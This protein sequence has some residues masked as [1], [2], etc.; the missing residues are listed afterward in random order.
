VFETIVR[1]PRPVD[2]HVPLEVSCL[3]RN[4]PQ[5]RFCESGGPMTTGSRGRAKVVEQRLSK[6][7]TRRM[8]PG[9][10]RSPG[11]R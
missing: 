8:D 1:L 9:S 11:R 3:T 6:Q 4:Y 10:R 5:R 2:A 7:A